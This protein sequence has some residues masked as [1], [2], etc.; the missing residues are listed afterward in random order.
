MFPVPNARRWVTFTPPSW[1]TPEPSGSE[2]NRSRRELASIDAIKT[3]AELIETLARLSKF[4]VSGPLGCSV[5]ID[6][7]KSDQYI[8][9]ISQSGLGLPDRDYYWD[10]KFKEKLTAY[11]AYIEQMLTLAKIADAKQ[12]AAD[13]VAL[14]TRV[15]KAQ[16]SKVENRDAD[17]TYNKMGL[18]ELAKLTPGF[19]WQLYFQNIGVKD[20]KELVVSQPSYLTAMAELMDTVPLA[21]WKVWLQMNTL[22][23]YASLL[24]KELAEADFAFYGT[25]L[26]DVP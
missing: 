16:W 22:H 4:G 18:A 20:V 11:Q 7:K 9:H 14:E 21:T 6:A 5:G 2:S 17:K 3:K 26:R 12:A 10:D 19:E 1:T 24:G 25:T 15:A 23:R 13:I 8:L